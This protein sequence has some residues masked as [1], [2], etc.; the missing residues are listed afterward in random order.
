MH[1]NA[2]AGYSGYPVAGYAQPGYPGTY[3]AP[4]H[5]TASAAA[6]DGT[7]AYGVAAASTGYP[8]APVQANSGAASTGQA[9]PASYPATYDPT[10]GSQR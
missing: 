5:P 6:T 8:A 9:P 4:Q 1:A 2:Y 10:R 7:N 3:A